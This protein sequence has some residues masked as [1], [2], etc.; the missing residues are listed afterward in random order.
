MTERPTGLDADG[1]A[2][3]LARAGVRACFAALDAPA[4]ETR[5]VG[6]C[7]RDALLGRTASD[8]D[9]ATTLLPQAVIARAR[10][11]GLKAVPTGIEHGTVT[12]VVDGEPH[13]VTTLREDVETDGRHAVVRFGRDFSRDAERRDFTINALSLSADGTLHDTTG[14][15]ADLAAG[16]VRFIG[17]A[18]TRIREDVLRIL[19]FFRFHARYGHGEPD[20]EGLAA[21]VAAR[22]GLFRLSRERVRAEFLKLLLTPRAVE[23]VATLS[24]TGLLSRIT[25]GVAERGRLARAAPETEAITRLG[26]LCVL[27]REDADRLQESLRLSKA[28]HAHL[29]AYADVLAHLHGRPGLDAAETPALVADH[30][31]AL[32]HTVL[33]IL[34]GEPRPLVTDEA[35]AA[36]DRMVRSGTRPVLPV[37]GADLVTRGVPPGPGVGRALRAARALWLAEGCPSDAAV[38]DRLIAHALA[39]LSPPSCQEGEAGAG[40]ATA[41]S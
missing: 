34:D 21:A 39:A 31:P 10:A 35:R 26:A 32:L 11:A 20:P 1:P 16:R 17:E 30:G 4:E 37:T 5:L 25:G 38:K 13:E 36:L 9:L 7:V 8:L 41:S 22:D 23:A 33:R 28:E 6:G 3:L 19:R 12:L 29:T 27:T 40:K 15:V 2:R 14:G 18:A 24:E